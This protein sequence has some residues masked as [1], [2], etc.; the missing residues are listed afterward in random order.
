VA[1]QNAD[2]Q[3]IALI[4]LNSAAAPRHFSVRQAGQTFGYSLQ[5][6]SAATFVWN[7]VGR[8]AKMLDPSR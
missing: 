2:D 3:S 6:G 5:S 1:F 7:M 8:H 4:V